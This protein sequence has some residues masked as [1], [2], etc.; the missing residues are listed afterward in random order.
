MLQSPLA[1][2]DNTRQR[3]GPVAG[4][5]LGGERVVLVAGGR[6]SL[7]A[8]LGCSCVL[9][10][11]APPKLASCQTPPLLLCCPAADP[12]AAKAV[13]VDPGQPTFVKAGTAFFPGRWADGSGRQAQ[14]QLGWQGCCVQ[15]CPAHVYLPISTLRPSPPRSSLTGSGLLVSDGE[16]WKR[17]RRLSNPAFRAAAVRQ[18]SEAM[19]GGAGA[20]LASPAWRDGVARDV[21]S[22]FNALTLRV[23]L[24]ALFGFRTGAG[25]EAAGREITGGC[26]GG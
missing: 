13:L 21:Y 23:T 7:M 25:D 26:G 5:L 3:Y 6:H 14:R 22:E 19:L 10:A 2:L 18:Y 12:T 24:E 17:Q 1:F 20:M 4:L 11:P 9:V 16:L 8:V 15:S